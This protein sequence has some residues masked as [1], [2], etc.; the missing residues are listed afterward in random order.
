MLTAAQQAAIASGT[1]LD[2]ST[3]VFPVACVVPPGEGTVE[4]NEAVLYRDGQR[5]V[6]VPIGYV[7]DVDVVPGVILQG[8]GE[9]MCI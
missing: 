3:L 1:F 4:V 9:N 7:P 5:T 6:G 8:A 2:L